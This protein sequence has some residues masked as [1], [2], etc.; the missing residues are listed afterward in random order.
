[1]AD[2]A[3]TGSLVVAAL[4]GGVGVVVGNVVAQATQLRRDRKQYERE[5]A[6]HER[7]RQEALEDERRKRREDRY[8]GLL[9]RL[10]DLDRPVL[11]TVLLVPEIVQYREEAES[12]EGQPMGMAVRGVADTVA[13]AC[14][15]SW[16]A[17]E[18]AHKAVTSA[19]FAAW[20]VASP[21]V[22]E[23]SLRVTDWTVPLA[24]VQLEMLTEHDFREYAA[25]GDG[26]L[27]HVDRRTY[28]THVTAML[29]ELRD[30]IA[31]LDRQLR[32]ELRL[33]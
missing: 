28:S 29:G 4:A 32:E 27:Q 2:A 13:S 16:K 18:E 6:R 10:T 11:G 20:A 14:R 26:P 7:E 23:Q 9:T 17:A 15:T 3:S 21:A 19:V 22:R 25:L 31:E 8:V 1:V 24:S 30:L 12:Y 33:D 5:D